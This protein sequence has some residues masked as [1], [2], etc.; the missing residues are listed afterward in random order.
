VRFVVLALCVVGLFVAIHMQRKAVLARAGALDEPSVVQT[1]RARA[2]GGAPNSAF[3]IAYY[4]LLAV[5]SSFFSLP[6]VHDVAL[7]A[8]I[9]AAAM[10]AY[11]A[12]SLL[13]VTKMPCVYCW[14]GHAVNWA[15]L[16]ILILYR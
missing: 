7:V 2:I 1:P 11:L 8:S 3:G 4:A 14:T 9:L 12:Y 15:L 16:V 10:S 6:I 13:F 5:A